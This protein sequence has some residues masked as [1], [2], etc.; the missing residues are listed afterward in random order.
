VLVKAFS[1]PPDDDVVHLQPPRDVNVR[2]SI[3]GIE[4]QLRALHL[5]VGERVTG[6]PVLE[7]QALLVSQSD[8]ICAAARHRRSDSP[9]AT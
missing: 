8:L 4:H 2:H 1:P 5:L 6:S 7:L 3:G 9:K